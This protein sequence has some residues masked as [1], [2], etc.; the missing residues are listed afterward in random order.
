MASAPLTPDDRTRYEWQLSA[1]GFGDEGQ[2]RLKGSTV[3]VSRIG[4]VGG[5]LAHQLAAAG[6]GK[7]I[8]AHA[9]SLRV[10]DLNR[11]LLMSQAGVDQSRVEQAARRLREF[12]PSIVIET[13][14]EN[15]SEQNVE[16]LVSKADVVASCAPLFAERLLMNRTAVRQGKPLVDCAM[17]E[18]EIQ[19]VTVIPG[20]TPCLA[21]L[22]PQEPPA[23]QRRFPVFGAV[24]GAVGCLG[25]MEI[26]KILSGVG[27][28]PT[29]RMLVGDLRT[30]EFR[31][32]QL[33]RD[34]KCAVCAR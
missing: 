10:S 9:G 25:A 4:G 1:A 20:Q 19:L 23:W 5:V 18:M 11:Q 8:L 24:A 27:G 14:P 30:P 16:A 22:Y 7:L 2:A 12:N 26:V 32:M 6:V 34:P 21:C 13:V 15:V 29:G 33:R 31:T 17:Y 3:L 28:A